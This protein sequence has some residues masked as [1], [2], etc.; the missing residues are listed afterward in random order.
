MLKIFSTTETSQKTNIPERSVRR[1]IAN[2]TNGFPNLE[3]IENGRKT[4]GATLETIRA[5]KQA[6]KTR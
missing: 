4:Y 5:V 2:G 6:R 3:V 1:Y